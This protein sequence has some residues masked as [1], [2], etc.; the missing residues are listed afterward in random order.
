[1]RNQSNNVDCSN[2][3]RYEE[4]QSIAVNACV[5]G[6]WQQALKGGN[7]KGTGQNAAKVLRLVRAKIYYEKKYSN[8]FKTQS[9]TLNSYAYP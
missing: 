8:K 5:N 1:M 7:M 9:I 2:N 4:L 6:K 3:C